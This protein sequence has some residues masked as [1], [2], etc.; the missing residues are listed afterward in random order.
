LR[1]LPAVVVA[2][3]AYLIPVSAL[4]ISHFW[5]GERVDATLVVG[6]LLVLTGLAL[7]QV[8]N[9]LVLARAHP[10]ISDS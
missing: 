2:P 5:L 10:A 7:T 9:F 6:A 8:R 3:F 1:R 4:T